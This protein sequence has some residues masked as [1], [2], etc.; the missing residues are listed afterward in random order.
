MRKILFATSE[1]YPLI[2]TGGLAD[3]SGSL[4]I[5]LKALGQDVRIIMPA[6]ADVLATLGEL[7]TTR[8]VQSS[9]TIDILEGMLPG[10][11]V[12]LWLVAH[13][14]AFD[15]PGNPYI[16]PTGKPWPDNA[17][18]FALL[19]RVTIEV[20]MN[21]V[22]FGWKPDI[23]H[24]NDWHTG[25]IPALLGDEPGRPATVFTIHNLAY[26]GV[27]PKETF[28]KLALPQRFWSY[29]SLEFHDQLSFIKGGL[30]YADRISTV[31]PN[32][33]MEIQ[34]KEFG[35]GME[36]L[37]SQRSEH[38]SG[39]LNGIDAEAW[40]PVKDPFIPSNYDADSLERKGGDKKALQHRFRL[41]EDRDTAV[42]AL[43]G[44]LVQQKGIDL[45]ID[46]LPKL[47]EMPLQLIILGSG[48][49]RYERT[50]KLWTKLYPDRIALTLGYDEALSHLI[51]AGADMFL[52]P[53]RFEPCGLNQMYSQRYGTVPIVRCVGGL[54]D[55]VEDA[56][57][58]NL[59]L[60]RASGVVFRE[61]RTSALLQAVSHALNLYRNKPLW[62]Q[63]QQ[64]GMNKDFSWRRS[65]AQYLDLY[66]QALA[67][68]AAQGASLYS[69]RSGA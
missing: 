49:K 14:G 8:I 34:S 6:Y 13:D 46:A 36:G 57:A 50:L 29:Q 56:D 51:E 30:I 43:V 58:S 26:Q 16:D 32:Y 60:G 41:E 66:E 69:R 61:A 4:P 62:T 55:T 44:R 47:M 25:L 7:K 35:C 19:C 39:I 64:A 2:K 9:G 11:T 5:A 65:A 15:R 52:M 20:A 38:L 3:V 1:V 54:A 21:R 27:F 53:S 31:S 10:S 42:I 37:L 59:A 18:R 17:E 68:C 23:V 67:D 63:I 12:P 45:V 33:A 28:K 22:G 24:C 40:N 48:E